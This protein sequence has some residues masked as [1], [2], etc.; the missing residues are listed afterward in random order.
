M[1]S[2]GGLGVT[3]NFMGAINS[4]AV[5]SSSLTLNYTPTSDKSI[6]FAGFTHN[7]YATAAM[8]T[9]AGWTLIG[10]CVWATNNRA[11]YLFAKVS[12]S[13][14]A[15]SVTGSTTAA[16]GFAGCVMEVDGLTQSPSLS[17]AL[18]ADVG[19]SFANATGCYI[20]G[21]GGGNAFLYPRGPWIAVSVCGATAT[22]TGTVGHSLSTRTT[23]GD[24]QAVSLIGPAATS[25]A[26][27]LGIARGTGLYSSGAS[28]SDASWSNSNAV[29]R[30]VGIVSALIYPF[31]QGSLMQ[32]AGA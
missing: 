5:A 20:A 1:P 14:T 8:S 13:M 3:Y 9:P 12:G 17:A 29:N 15:S 32:G 28:P 21:V 6:L 22:L 26:L 4:T 30:N 10:S 19:T 24:S 2:L 27:G 25:T 11:T 31:A 18:A 16:T 7:Q 23:L